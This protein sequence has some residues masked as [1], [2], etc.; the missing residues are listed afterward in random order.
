MNLGLW[1]KLFRLV[2]LD[3]VPLKSIS[4]MLTISF[5]GLGSTIRGKVL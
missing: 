4:D 1:H 2:G 5:K 3:W